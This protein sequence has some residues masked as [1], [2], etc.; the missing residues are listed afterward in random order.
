[1]SKAESRKCGRTNGDDYAMSAAVKE[2]IR[3]AKE[4][5]R[6][7]YGNVPFTCEDKP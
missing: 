4:L 3:L 5:V 1:M 2:I 6:R 7:G